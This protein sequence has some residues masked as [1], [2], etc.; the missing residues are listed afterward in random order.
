[1]PS[2]SPALTDQWND[3][4]LRRVDPYAMAK[5]GI[6]LDWL[7]DVRGKTVLVAGCG[8][9]ELCALLA[10]RGAIV[11]AFDLEQRNLDLARET[12]QRL[13]AEF[14]TF[15]AS[16]DDVGDAKRYDVVAA[17]DVIEHVRDDRAA[18][19]KLKRL[20]KPAGRL[21]LTVPA[22]AE[23]MGYHDEILGHFRRYSRRTLRPLVEPDFAIERIRYFGFFL[24]PVTLIV[25]RWLRRP[26]PVAAMSR[27][28][29]SPS[30]AGRVLALVLG[31]ER[32]W[33]MGAGTSLLL[34]ARDGRDGADGYG[35]AT[36]AGRTT[37]SM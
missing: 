4:L 2:Q 6:L 12:A 18:V 34:V 21:V 32:R 27:D 24:I 3:F 9:G 14:N 35:S 23:L 31:F 10:R 26:Y 20:V 8:S 37:V 7:G 30:F 22:R 13:G 1:V 36:G 16:I 11:D 33:S 28:E 19:L 15:V 25:S 5:Y 17:T 29:S